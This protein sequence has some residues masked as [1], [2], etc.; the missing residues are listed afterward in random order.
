[1]NYFIETAKYAFRVRHSQDCRKRV[2]LAIKH[3]VIT[4]TLKLF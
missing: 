4:D 3:S 2:F 1:M